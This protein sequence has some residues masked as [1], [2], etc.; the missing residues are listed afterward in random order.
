MESRIWPQR[1]KLGRQNRIAQEDK[2]R[3]VR[4]DSS[5]CLACPNFEDFHGKI[6]VEQTLQIIYVRHGLLLR[7][8]LNRLGK[9]GVFRP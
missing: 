2:P 9:I 5:R 1:A 4:L 6:S 3:T 8:P 7:S